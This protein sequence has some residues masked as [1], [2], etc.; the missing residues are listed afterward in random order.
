MA[1]ED[2]TREQHVEGSSDRGFGLVVTG[3]FLLVALGPLRH[4]Q[5]P[6]SWAFAVASVFALI[7]LLKPILLSRLNWLWTKLGIL[8][9][10]VVSPIA[11]AILFYGVLTPVAVVMR[12]TGRDPLRLKLDPEAD[13]YWI[14]RKP[15][16]PPPDS[17][18]NQF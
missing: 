12:F 13:S 2:L 9:G 5:T 18:T 4:G 11:L 17:M 7:A 1:H 6:R 3:V 14:E 15:P 16:G 10:K 8:L